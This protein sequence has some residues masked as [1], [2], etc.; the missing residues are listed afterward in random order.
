M[1]SRLQRKFRCQ[2]VP[3]YMTPAIPF[4]DKKHPLLHL[5]GS[6]SPKWLCRVLLHGV[7]G[8]VPS[9]AWMISVIKIC[10]R[11]VDIALMCC[12]GEGTE[13]TVPPTT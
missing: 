1:S 3:P 8:S 2:V 11:C 6:V 5:C 7:Y 9:W 12:L 13:G 4:P 10:G